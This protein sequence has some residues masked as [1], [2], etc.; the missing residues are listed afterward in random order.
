MCKCIYKYTYTESFIYTACILKKK[1]TKKKQGTDSHQLPTRLSPDQMIRS[2][3][4]CIM[5]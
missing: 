4:S 5:D 2:W 3:F 1:K